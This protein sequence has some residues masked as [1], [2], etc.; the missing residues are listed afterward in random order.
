MTIFHCLKL[1]IPPTWRPKP[2]I[3]TGDVNVGTW[4]SR[5]RY[6]YIWDSG[7]RSSVLR[8]SFLGITSLE[9]S[10]TIP[11]VREGISQQISNSLVVIKIWSRAPHRSATSRQTGRLTVGRNIT[12]TES[13][14]A[15]VIWILSKCYKIPRMWESIWC[16]HMRP[17]LIT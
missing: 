12:L 6:S 15:E 2:G 8:C 1:E 4:P 5:W 10:C 16:F 14:C 17:Y 11:L 9:R 7:I 3:Y 13:S